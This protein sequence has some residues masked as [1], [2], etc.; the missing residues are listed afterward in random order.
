MTLQLV[1]VLGLLALLA[2]SF[3]LPARAEETLPEN[4]SSKSY[5]SGWACDIGYRATST[6]CEKVVVPPHGYATDTAYGRGWE[7]EYGY[8]RKGM[9]CQLIAVPEHGYLDS[10]GTSWSCERGYSSDGTVCQKIQVPDNAYLRKATNA[11][12]SRC[13]RMRTSIMAAMA[14]LATAP[15]NRSARP[16][17]CHK[18]RRWELR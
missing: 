5:G 11:P 10:F 6:E 3:A 15:M 9:K 1:C 18:Q 14:G 12:P 2:V 8:V 7:C 17:N 13:L 16:A 4:S